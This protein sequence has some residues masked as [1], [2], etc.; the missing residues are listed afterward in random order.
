MPVYV[1][2][3]GIS[4]Q[5]EKIC[6]RVCDFS[7]AYERVRCWR[8]SLLANEPPSN[9]IVCLLYGLTTSLRT[10]HKA[11]NRRNCKRDYRSNNEAPVLV[12]VQL[13]LL[14]ANFIETRRA[15][16]RAAGLKFFCAST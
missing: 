8:R 2:I 6:C 3:L 9:A 11:C 10:S 7:I 14:S 13:F 5:M 4:K 15:D 16:A 12:H 1:I